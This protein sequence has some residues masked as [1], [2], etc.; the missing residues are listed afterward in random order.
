M[1]TE[2]AKVLPFGETTTATTC[3]ESSA[4][5]LPLLLPQSQIRQELYS[6]TT[7]APEK[8]QAL[9]RL[10]GIHQPHP[11]IILMAIKSYFN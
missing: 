5:G 1:K 2:F 10:V 3:S 11:I 9:F 8:I 4:T 7:D 6:K